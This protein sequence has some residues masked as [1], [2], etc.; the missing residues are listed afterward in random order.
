M[1]VSS[2]SPLH[3]PIA[4]HVGT[5]EW[6]RT[7]DEEGVVASSNNDGS[8][9]VHRLRDEGGELVEVARVGR[10]DSSTPFSHA[11][12]K[13]IR[14]CIDRHTH[15]HAQWDAHSLYGSPIEVRFPS[16][17]TTISP[18]PITPKHTHTGMDHRLCR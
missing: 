10:T 15:A 4:A 12:S 13:A 14:T 3:A 8:A 9:C 16:P 2:S 17:N 11:T 1:G 5:Q 18:R 7:R 6:A